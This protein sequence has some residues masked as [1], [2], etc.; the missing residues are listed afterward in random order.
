M[1]RE[2]FMN[3]FRI[4]EQIYDLKKIKCKSATPFKIHGKKG[5]TKVFIFPS[6]FLQKI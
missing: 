3:F 4:L 1:L 6:G 2:A 5:V